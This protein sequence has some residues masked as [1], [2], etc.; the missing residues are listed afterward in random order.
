MV[1]R[2]LRCSVGRLHYIPAEEIATIKIEFEKDV[3]S[4]SPSQLSMG[5]STWGQE[6]EATAQKESWQRKRQSQRTQWPIATGAGAPSATTNCWSRRASTSMDDYAITAWCSN[7]FSFHGIIASGAKTEGSF[8]AAEEG[9]SR[10][11][12]SRTATICCRRD[13]GRDQEGR[14]NALHSSGCTDKG[15]GR[16]GHSP[17]CQEQ[18]HVT[19][20][21]L[22]DYAAGKIQ[23][24]HRSLPESGKCTPGEYQDRQRQAPEGQRR[25]Q[26]ERRGSYSDLRR[27]GRR[28]GHLD[29]GVSRQDPRRTCTYDGEPSK[30][31][32]AGSTG[33][34]EQAEEERKAKRP[35]KKEE[36]PKDV[37][38]PPGNSPSLQ[39][40]GVP[41]H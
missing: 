39:P 3:V 15:K 36:E 23:A 25:F 35:R 33:A 11:L 1:L 22:P 30:A 19:V 9:Q 16:T 32:R 7:I 17:P 29:E 24:V 26:L 13:Q 37:V 40:F 34:S 28:Q 8:H 38:M 12:D 4:D 31:V 27:R 20:E 6:S 41:G 21:I 2:S 18:P 10:V 5:R 14:Q